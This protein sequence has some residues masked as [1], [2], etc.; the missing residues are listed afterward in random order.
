MKYKKPSTLE[1]IKIYA[2]L[3]KIS[4]KKVNRNS[5]FIDKEYNSG[6]WNR[7]FDSIEFETLKGH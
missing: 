6:K 3:I 5:A 7:S 4:L 1:I 2:Y